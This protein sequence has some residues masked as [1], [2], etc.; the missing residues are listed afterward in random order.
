MYSPLISPHL[1]MLFHSFFSF[2]VESEATRRAEFLTH[3]LVYGSAAQ[4]WWGLGGAVFFFQL[5]HCIFSGALNWLL[6]LPEG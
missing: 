3:A 1:V 5:C 2:H 4:S 6:R